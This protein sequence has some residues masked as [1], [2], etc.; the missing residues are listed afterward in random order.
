M[1][2][3]TIVRTGRT[4]A[5]AVTRFA[6]VAG[7]CAAVIGGA[8]AVASGK[9]IASTA[10]VPAAATFADRFSAAERACIP[11]AWPYFDAGCLKTADGARPR[12][13]RIIAIDHQ[14]S[15]R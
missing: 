6:A 2:R 11:R 9:S 4:K 3:S 1:R 14:I 10:S 5:G 13:A 15:A 12:P 7:I 8:A